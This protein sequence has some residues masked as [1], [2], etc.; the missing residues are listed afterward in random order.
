LVTS[1]NK[2]I[3]T[4]TKEL[5]KKSLDY[6]KKQYMENN[7]S[8]HTGNITLTAYKKRYK[9]GFI[10]SSGDDEIAVYNEFGT[11]IAGVGT[12]PLATDTGYEYNVASPYK[13]Y[14]PEGAIAQYGLK[15]CEK[16]TTP[17]TWWY[18]KDGKW[19]H[20]EGMKDGGKKMYYGLVE[21]IRDVYVNDLK[22]AVSQTIGNY[23]GKK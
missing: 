4:S 15:N 12:N 9:N 18:L 5:G 20:T 11:G 7:L 21:E 14:I 16:W 22:V 3:E 19:H 2:G 10:I 13:G 23:G 8:S 17:N 1:L 6:M